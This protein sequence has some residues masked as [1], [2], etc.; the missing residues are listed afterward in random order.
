MRQLATIVLFA[1]ALLT[2]PPAAAEDAASVLAKARADCAS[3]DGG[4]LTVAE[5]AVR[6]VDVT[7]DGEPEEV[8]DYSGLQCSTAATFWCGTGGCSLDV[9]VDGR[10]YGFLARDWT[11]VPWHG[12]QVLLLRVHPSACGM[13]PGLPPCVRALTWSGNAWRTVAPPAN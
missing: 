7:G 2:A 8:V 1:L 12:L 6:E 11:V 3:F 4:T 9:I 13:A 5:G 10:A